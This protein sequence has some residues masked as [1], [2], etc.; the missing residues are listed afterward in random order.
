MER[1]DLMEPSLFPGEPHQTRVIIAHQSH[2][3]LVH[4]SGK[5]GEGRLPVLQRLS[6]RQRI[7]DREMCDCSLYRTQ[8]DDGH[9]D[10]TPFTGAVERVRNGNE[11]CGRG[12][13]REW[14]SPEEYLPTAVEASLEAIGMHTLPLRD[15]TQAS[16][17]MERAD[18]ERGTLPLPLTTTAS[19]ANGPRPMTVT[20]LP[21]ACSDGPRLRVATG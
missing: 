10:V 1:A 4:V 19:G 7:D 2:D 16:S 13:S 9:H 5:T 20:A 18:T 3:S 8:E 12:R 15:G 6:P 21:S 17:F 14:C 11:G